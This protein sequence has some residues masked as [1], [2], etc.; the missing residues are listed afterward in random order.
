MICKNDINVLQIKSKNQE[1]TLNILDRVIEDLKLEHATKI[2]EI[3]IELTD[4]HKLMSI[5]KGNNFG[6]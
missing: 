2:E 5:Y 4:N 3:K 1:E 6:L